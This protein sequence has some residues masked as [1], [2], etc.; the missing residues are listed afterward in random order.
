MGKPVIPSAITPV[1]LLLPKLAEGLD[2]LASQMPERQAVSF[3]PHCGLLPDPQYAA[4][5]HNFADVIR[6]VIRDQQRFP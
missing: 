2:G 5:Q 1:E 4:H 3:G 6:I